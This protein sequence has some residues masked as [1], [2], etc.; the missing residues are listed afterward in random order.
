[1]RCMPRPPVSLRG[2]AA[3]TA[4]FISRILTVL[5]TFSPS[6]VRKRE[7]NEREIAAM[8]AAP[9][10]DRP[11]VRRG[12][13]GGDRADALWREAMTPTIRATH[14]RSAERR[15]PQGA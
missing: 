8:T 15:L 2:D 7:M 4:A 9:V 10:R 14:P 3:S 6:F 12:G 1:M 13:S 5:D 11:Q